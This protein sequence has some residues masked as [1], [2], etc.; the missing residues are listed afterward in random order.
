MLFKTY[1]D[2]LCRARRVSSVWLLIHIILS[3]DQKVLFIEWFMK[4]K[5]KE[6]KIAI[7]VRTWPSSRWSPCVVLSMAAS[8][9][10]FLSHGR[11]EGKKRENGKENGEEQEEKGH[12]GL[13]TAIIVVA[14]HRVVSLVRPVRCCFLSL[15]CPSFSCPRCPW[16]AIIAAVSH[17]VSHPPLQWAECSTQFYKENR[18]TIIC[19]P[20]DR[21]TY[22][23]QIK[24]HRQCKIY[25]KTSQV[26]ITSESFE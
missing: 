8:Y 18:I 23:E 1:S 6:K 11:R 3:L 20:K 10:S 21:L 17:R 22:I 12:T 7:P 25:Y 16:M 19:W 15:F 4:R 26:L 14:V 9:L 24:H 2:P 5:K 13:A